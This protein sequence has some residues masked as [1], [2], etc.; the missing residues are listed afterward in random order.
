M[1]LRVLA[2]ASRDDGFESDEAQGPGHLRPDLRRGRVHLVRR[3]GEV[4][5]PITGETLKP[6][7]PDGPEPDFLVRSTDVV[8]LTAAKRP[9]KRG[10]RRRRRGLSVVTLGM[11]WHGWNGH[12]LMAM[13]LRSSE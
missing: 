8:W 9:R 1:R 11:G 2:T 12:V 6:R 4:K 10:S 7:P 13:A 5:H 3:R